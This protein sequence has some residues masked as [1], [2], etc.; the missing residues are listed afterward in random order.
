MLQEQTTEISEAEVISDQHGELTPFTAKPRSL[1]KEEVTERKRKLEM[2]SSLS[3]DE[4]VEI[5]GARYWNASKGDKLQGIFIGWTM[6][7][8]TDDN[9]EPIQKPTALIDTTEGTFGCNTIQ[10]I[11]KFKSIPVDSPVYVECIFSQPKKMKEYRV[12]NLE[13]AA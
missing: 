8:S 2:V 12:V 11:E 7:N 3:P 9:N 4:G 5:H 6:F 13:K 10:F 1:T